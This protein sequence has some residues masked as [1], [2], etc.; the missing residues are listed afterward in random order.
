MPAFRQK[1]VKPRTEVN[2]EF[3]LAEQ[4]KADGFPEFVREYQFCPNRQFRLDLAIVALRLGVEIEGG[5]WTGGAHGTGKA[6]LRDMEKSNLLTLL[7][8]SLLRYTPIQ[9]RRGL[10]IKEIKAWLEQRTFL[11]E[12]PCKGSYPP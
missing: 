6:T 3:T 5:I 11:V 10:A 1:Y 8:W 4:L 9:V 2:A 12:L 7:G